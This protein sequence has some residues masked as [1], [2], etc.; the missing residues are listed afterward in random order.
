MLK[1]LNRLVLQINYDG[2]LS[3]TAY[4]ILTFVFLGIIGGLGWCFYRAV[5]AAGTN[6][7][8][9]LPDDIGDENNKKS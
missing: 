2:Q 7:E 4:L 1:L 6:S 9:Q 3:L 5:K 8:P